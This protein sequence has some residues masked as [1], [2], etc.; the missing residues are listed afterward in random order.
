MTLSIADLDRTSASKPGS[1]I[2]FEFGLEVGFVF[3]VV[4]K[5]CLYSNTQ[6]PTSKVDDF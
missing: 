3:K 4:V 2:E 6:A 1:E 5:F